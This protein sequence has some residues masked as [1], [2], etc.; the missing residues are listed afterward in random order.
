[1]EQSAGLT[2]RQ[3]RL[4]QAVWLILQFI[5]TTLFNEKVG[6]SGEYAKQTGM[7]PVESGV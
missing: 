5:Q 1:V 2:A 3:R 7:F 6:K 4:E